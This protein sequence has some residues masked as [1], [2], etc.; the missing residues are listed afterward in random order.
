M[1]EVFLRAFLK[2]EK[3]SFGLPQVGRLT[4]VVVGTTGLLR[5]GVMRMNRVGTTV[6][7]VGAGYEFWDVFR[8]VVIRII[9]GFN[10]NNNKSKI[11]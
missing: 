6:G 2:S 7:F 4:T 3:R 8:Q 1:E 10:N 11:R 9:R 5:A